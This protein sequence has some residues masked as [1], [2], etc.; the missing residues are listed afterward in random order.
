MKIDCGER[1]ELLAVLMIYVTRS[2]W[3]A[4]LVRWIE[5]FLMIIRTHNRLPPTSAYSYIMD[6]GRC[7]QMSLILFW[8]SLW[9]E[10][11]QHDRWRCEFYSWKIKRLRNVFHLLCS[12]IDVNQERSANLAQIVSI[13][14]RYE[15][16]LHWQWFAFDMTTAKQHVLIIR[17]VIQKP[18]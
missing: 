18:P 10:I 7:S 17:S 5:P 11:E 9:G 8:S 2:G 6:F 4:K 1:L 16:S 3:S 12:R 14:V 13:C 15:L